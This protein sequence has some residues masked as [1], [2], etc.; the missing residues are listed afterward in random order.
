MN[1]FDRAQ[2]GV[3]NSFGRKKRSEICTVGEIVIRPM[4]QEEYPL[5]AEFLY[6]AI[7]QPDSGNLL[8]RE[9]IN[10]PDLAVYIQDFGQNNDFCL[11]AESGGRILGAV[12]TRILADGVK[13]YG[14]IDETT[15]EFA[16]SVKK[17]FRRQGIGA[18][19]MQEMIV[20]LKKMGFSRA[21]LSVDKENYAYKLYCSLGFQVVKEQENDYLMMLDL[22]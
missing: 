15:P 1:I 20:L 6:D 21:S 8:P 13:G 17:E 22:K 5:L 16:I 9:V 11:V 3:W 12:W 4:K 2:D 18:L 7:F 10:Q 14:N 19:L